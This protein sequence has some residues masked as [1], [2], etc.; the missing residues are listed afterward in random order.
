MSEPRQS[1]RQSGYEAPT[2]WTNLDEIAVTRPVNDVE[3]RHQTLEQ[4]RSHEQ[5]GSGGFVSE[6]TLPHGPPGILGGDSEPL[7]SDRGRVSRVISQVYV[8]SNL[9]FFSILGT[10]ARLGIAAINTYPGAPVM[11]GTLWANFAGCLVMGFLL[12]DRMLFQHDLGV[13]RRSANTANGDNEGSDSGVVA[14]ASAKKAHGAIK[15]TIPLYIG[16][17]T[18]FCG[19]LTTFSSFIKD[20][21]LAL[22]NDM[23]TPGVSGLPMP[24]NGGYSFEALL[25]V[26]FVTASLSLSGIFV[27]AHIAIAGERITPSVSGPRTR[28]V[29]DVLVAVLGWGSWLGA[30]ILAIVPPHDFWRGRAIFSLVFAPLGCLL[31]FHLSLWLNGKVASFPVGTFVANMVGTVVLGMAW[32]IAHAQIGGVIG[33]QLL[34]GVEDGF[35]GCL[36]TIS[37]WA[38]E[39][40]S[41]KRRHAYVYGLASVVV[42]LV[43]MIAIMGGK[44]WSGGFDALLCAT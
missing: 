3:E 14:K 23:V 6:Q 44:R 12:E 2:D 25:A 26:I 30:V 27:G 40:S 29:L 34:Q 20:S 19:S 24:R 35:C 43:L 18:G 7:A 42:A 31:R 21:F 22:S 13:Q 8:S 38:A 17:A 15:K 33:C 16:L 1:A 4:V 28:R 39:L 10:L 41:L 11:F 9:I 37:T 32:D 36:T 5:Q